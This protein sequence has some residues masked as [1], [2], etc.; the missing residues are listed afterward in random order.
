[1]KELNLVEVEQV[2]GAGRLADAGAHIGGGIGRI[3]D[4][5]LGNVSTVA[6]DAGSALGQGIGEFIEVITGIH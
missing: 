2:S 4:A 6:A 3:V 1:M 5:A